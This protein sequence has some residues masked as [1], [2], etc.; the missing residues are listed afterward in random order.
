[1]SIRENSAVCMTDVNS[2]SSQTVQKIRS[3]WGFIE[4]PSALSVFTQIL[5][6]YLNLKG[7]L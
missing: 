2:Y 1:M 6:N 3:L 5:N 7:K 4:Y